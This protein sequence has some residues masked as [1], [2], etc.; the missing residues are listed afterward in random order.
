MHANFLAKHPWW[1]VLIHYVISFFCG[2]AS[3]NWAEQLTSTIIYEFMVQLEKPSPLQYA[4][5]PH[6]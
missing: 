1:I 6:Q 5:C 4:T 3:G 2:I